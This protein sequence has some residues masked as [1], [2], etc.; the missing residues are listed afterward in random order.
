VITI[1]RSQERGHFNFGWLDTYHT[2]SFGD[3]FDPEHTQY[4]RLRVINDDRVGGGAGFPT[5]PHR[6]MEIVTIML[7]GRLAHKDSLGTVQEIRP[8]EVQVMSAGTGI[9]HSEFNPSDTE[10]AHLLQVWLLPDRKGHE[11]RYEQRAFELKPGEWTTLV[12][13]QGPLTINQNATIARAQLQPGQFVMWPARDG[14]WLH[15]AT[16]KVTANGHE[17]NA[18][19]AMAIENEPLTVEG[20]DDGD[21]LLFDLA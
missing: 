15:V 9:R 21:L 11:P 16:G 10:E 5:H 4:R 18:G 17:L 20:L 14:V 1:R 2:F 12:S 6:D 13:P 7:K 3:Y 19:D 8:G